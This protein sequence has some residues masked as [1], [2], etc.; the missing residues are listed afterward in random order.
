M[1]A[2]KTTVGRSLA[3][4]LDFK[5]VD[6]DEEIEKISEQKINELFSQGEAYFRKIESEVLVSV[7]NNHNQVVAT[8]GGVVVSEYNRQILS[9]CS[10]EGSLVI[11]L[12]ASPEVI[13]ER[14]K[15]CKN[16]PL[17]QVEE[18]EMRFRSLLNSRHQ[19]Y[20]TLAD[21]IIDTSKKGIEEIKQELLNKLKE[22]FC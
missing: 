4:S 21:I 9:K 11:F 14:V 3:K 16:R 6:L 5:F 8:G 1:G 18:P 17:L 10:R 20:Q 15:F 7:L 13:W 19:Y 12:D 22:R 2:G